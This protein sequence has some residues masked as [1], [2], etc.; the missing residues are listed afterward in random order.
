MKLIFD[1][2]NLRNDCNYKKKRKMVIAIR[3]P[4]ERYPVL[5]KRL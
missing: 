5:N 1:G 3:N 2:E 4:T